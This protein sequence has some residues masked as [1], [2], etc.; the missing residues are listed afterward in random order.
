MF[1]VPDCQF[2]ATLSGFIVEMTDADDQSIPRLLGDGEELFLVV[3]AVRKATGQRVCSRTGLRWCV[4]GLASPS[5]RV[6]LESLRIGSKRMTSVEAVRRFIGT[7]NA[8]RTND[9]PTAGSARH[10]S[11]TADAVLS[12]FGCGRERES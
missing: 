12:S 9:A 11:D 10:R 5:G 2:S 4:T 8:E 1:P 6:R 7:V 3:H